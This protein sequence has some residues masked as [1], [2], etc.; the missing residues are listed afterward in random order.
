MKLA[1]GLKVLFE[2]TVDVHPSLQIV[3]GHVYTKMAGDPNHSVPPPVRVALRP[4]P[5]AITQAKIGC[6]TIAAAMM[7][8]IKAPRQ[9][10]GQLSRKMP[11]QQRRAPSATTDRNVAA[12]AQARAARS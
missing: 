4:R 9:F 6:P 3:V 2:R 11:V 10:E 5:R 7:N 12:I 1:S 8:A